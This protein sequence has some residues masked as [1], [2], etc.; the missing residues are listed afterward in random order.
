MDA[1]VIEGHEAGGHIGPVSTGVLAEQILPRTKEVPVF[2][3]GG[4]GSG[5]L[6]V[7]YLMMGAQFD[8]RVPVIP[9]R[10]LI[11]ESTRDFN[12]LQLGLV[13]QIERDAMTP[14][15]ASLKLEEFWIGALRKT[16]I[17]GDIER[18]SVMAGQS[19]GL[20]DEIQPGKEIIRKLIDEALHEL[21]R[22]GELA[23]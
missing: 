4:I 21:K 22:L 7:H 15:E 17:E 9:V 14:R 1:L 23:E 3:T 10:A 19:V 5:Q 2:V 12:T 11:N 6:M 16:A 8:P 20:V 13:A 18:G